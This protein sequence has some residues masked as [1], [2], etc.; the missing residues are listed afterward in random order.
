MYTTVLGW[1]GTKQIRSRNKFNKTTMKVLVLNNLT[2]MMRV[3]RVT[4]KVTMTT[5]MDLVAVDPMTMKT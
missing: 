1:L 3:R 4:Q 5:K 2:S